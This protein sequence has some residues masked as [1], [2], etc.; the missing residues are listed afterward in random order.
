M[1]QNVF[2]TYCTNL[3]KYSLIKQ[4]KTH[5]GLKVK[6]HARILTH[7]KRYTAG[8]SRRYAEQPTSYLTD[9][10]HRSIFGVPLQEYATLQSDARCNET[11]VNI[12]SAIMA[13]HSDHAIRMR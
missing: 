13:E 12:R 2:S 3:C 10:V 5:Y 4:R 6:F 8:T 1:L 7:T 9:Q 11:Q